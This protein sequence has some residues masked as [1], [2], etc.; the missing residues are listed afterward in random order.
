MW[1]WKRKHKEEY[2]N[3]Y[4]WE[5]WGEICSVDTNHPYFRKPPVKTK[6]RLIMKWYDIIPYHIRTESIEGYQISS[7]HVEFLINGRS[8]PARNSFD[9]NNVDVDVNLSYYLYGI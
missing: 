6:R 1:F 8:I 3:K 5:Y 2:K 9:L 4:Y 7:G